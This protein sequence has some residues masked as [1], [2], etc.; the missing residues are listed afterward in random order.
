MNHNEVQAL[1]SLGLTL[2]SPA[3]LLG[4]IVFGLIGLV[5]YRQGKRRQNAHT[6]WLGVALMFYPYAVSATWLLYA[7]GSA[8]CLGLYVYRSEG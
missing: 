7:V 4:A 3:Y 2:P 1:Q 8:L 6:R 5:A